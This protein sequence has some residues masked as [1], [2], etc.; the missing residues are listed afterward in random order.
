MDFKPE[1]FEMLRLRAFG[2][3]SDPAR[4]REIIELAETKAQKPK[5]DSEPNS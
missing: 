1:D 2:K 3:I 4:R 5:P